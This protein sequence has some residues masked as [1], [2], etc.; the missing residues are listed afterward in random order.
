MWKNIL[1]TV[2]PFFFSKTKKQKLVLANFENEKFFMS[3]QANGNEK[4]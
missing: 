3:F 1:I 2:F 4:N